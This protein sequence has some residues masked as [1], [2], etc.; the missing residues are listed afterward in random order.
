MPFRL[1]EAG[2]QFN[3][4]QWIEAR[5]RKSN[6]D[7]R[8]ESHR[9]YVD[10]I[11][12]D[13]KPLSTKNHWQERWPWIDRLRVFPTFADIE[14][15]RLATSESLALLRPKR[16]LNLEVR[17][18][19]HADWTDDERAKLLQEQLQGNL[20]ARAE[21]EQ[22]VR[23]LRKIPFDFYYTYVCDTA[24]GE[25]ERQHKIVDWEA[26]ALYWNCRRSHGDRWEQPFRAKL[27]ADLLETDLMFLMGNIHR[28]QDQWLIVSLIYPPRQRPALSPQ[29]SLF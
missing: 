1:I 22:Q 2:K 28:F 26:G 19:R 29:T 15:R 10:T 14:A 16:I 17:P 13:E 6:D 11:E 9:I 3:K 7:R 18:A 8:P 12:C 5:I 27:E 20:F 25:V 4:W 23:E 24:A 21:A